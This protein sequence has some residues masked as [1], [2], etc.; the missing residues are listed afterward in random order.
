MY[1]LIVLLIVG[2]ILAFQAGERQQALRQ[3]RLDAVDSRHKAFKTWRAQWTAFGAA[4]VAWALL[5]LA[6]LLTVIMANR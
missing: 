4:V 1:L 2:A 5:G 3:A 6:V